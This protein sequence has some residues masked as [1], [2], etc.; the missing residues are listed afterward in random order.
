MV[1]TLDDSSLFE[2]HDT[3]GLFLTVDRR[4]AMTKVVLSLH[5]SD[6]YLPERFASVLVSIRSLLPHQESVPADLRLL[7]LRWQAAVSVPGLQI[8]T[9]AGQHWYHN[10]AAVCVIKLSALAS[11]AAAIH[12]F[13]RCIQLAITNVFHNSSGK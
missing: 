12:F 5:Q 4:C 13:V 6:P 10:P 7:L 11:F 2:N 1:S 9:V 3:V 8:C